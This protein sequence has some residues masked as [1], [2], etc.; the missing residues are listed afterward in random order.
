MMLVFSVCAAIAAVNDVSAFVALLRMVRETDALV[1]PLGGRTSVA[2][3][4]WKRSELVYWFAYSISLCSFV[5]VGLATS[6]ALVFDVGGVGYLFVVP[7]VVLAVAQFAYHV[8]GRRKANR[9][10]LDEVVATVAK[11]H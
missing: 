7:T 8:L 5:L 1:L 6:L 9:A 3:D 11:S 4:A 2:F 10:L